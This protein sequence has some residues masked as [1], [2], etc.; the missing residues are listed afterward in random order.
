MKKIIVFSLGL[1]FFAAYAQAQKYYSKDAAVSFNATSPGS[2]E[3]IEAKTAKGTLVLDAATGAVEMSVLIKGFHF[4]RALMEEHFNE[5]YLE[6]DKFKDAKFKGTITNFTSLSLSKDGTYDGEVAGVLT[7]HGVSKN[8]NTTAQ[9]TV[10]NGAV[11]GVQSSFS[12]L[13]ADYGINIPSLVQ[14][15]VSRTVKINVKAALKPLK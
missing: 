6:S 4:E 2:P 3:A 7:V 11:S 5:N 15:K 13:A 10:V 1:F 9:I 12:I 14:D 8:V